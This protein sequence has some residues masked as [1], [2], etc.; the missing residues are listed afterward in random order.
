M[1]GTEEGVKH[2]KAKKFQHSRSLPLM[3]S[4][5]RKEKH[6]DFSHA[7]KAPALYG[8]PGQL[9]TDILFTF[10]GLLC[11]PLLERNYQLISGYKHCA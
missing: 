8:K 7:Q 2:I 10:I 9:L 1:R 3:H 6:S 4:L 5:C 11:G